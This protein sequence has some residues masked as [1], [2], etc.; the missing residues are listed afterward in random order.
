IPL[1]GKVEPE[2]AEEGRDEAKPRRATD[3]LGR[4]PAQQ[5]RDVDLPA[6][7]RGHPRRLVREAAE[8][9][10]L[11]RGRLAPVALEGFQHQLDPGIETHE[12]VGSGSNGRS[13]E[14]FLPYALDVLPGHHPACAGH[15]GAVES[16][17]IGPGLLE[18]ESEAVGRKY[19]DFLDRVLEDLGCPTTVALEGE[20]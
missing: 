8:H 11:D 10:A 5:E 6:L 2:D 16:R 9:E 18:D 3:L 7:E 15:E 20:L 1:V 13:T 4:R 14:A 17:K 19:L 12:L